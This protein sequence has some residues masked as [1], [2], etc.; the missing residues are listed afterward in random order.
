MK[1]IAL[2]VRVLLGVSLVF[3]WVSCKKANPAAKASQEK[4]TFAFIIDISGRF[5]HIAQA[6]CQ[7]AG[8]EE[9]VN[10]EFHVPGQSTAAQQ[11]QIIE[12]L[13]ARGCRGIAICPLSPESLKRILDEVSEYMYVIC[14]G[15]DAPQSKR[16]CYIG[17]N[18]YEAGRT[19]GEMLKKA[20]P[21]GGEV[22]VFAA[23]MDLSNQRERSQ[24]AQDALAGSNCKVV[25][26][27]TDQ[28]AR[29]RAQSNVRAVV[30]KYPQLKGI[31]GC[32][33]YN[34]PCAVKALQDYSDCNVAVVGFDEDI[35]TMEAIRKGQIYCSVAQQPYEFGY[36]SMKMLAQL[37]RGEKVA[38]PA[39][40]MI[41]VPVIIITKD[42]VDAISKDVEQKLSTLDIAVK[43]Y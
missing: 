21:N 31:I 20:L 36:R 10:V 29:D 3:S 25:G 37:V 41:Y 30:A 9:G 16:V 8:R 1:T 17:T 5:W 23:T 28:A 35:D 27:F 14:Q 26:V 7:Q 43:P 6:G 33:G 39:D 34:A 2:G 13:V 22:A 24:G 11:Q 32:A 19:A 15:S 38:V 4:P 12:S 40:K 18:N 42:N